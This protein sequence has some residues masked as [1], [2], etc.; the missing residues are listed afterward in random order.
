VRGRL[1]IALEK[2]MNQHPRMS[3]QRSPRLRFWRKS[4]QDSRA[5]KGYRYFG[6]A[7][8]EDFGTCPLV[9]PLWTPIKATR[10]KAILSKRTKH[11][12]RIDRDLFNQKVLGWSHSNSTIVDVRGYAICGRSQRQS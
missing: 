4:H 2:I 9:L 1:G 6:I 11:R 12:N 8:R 7:T 5:A 10:S 3:P